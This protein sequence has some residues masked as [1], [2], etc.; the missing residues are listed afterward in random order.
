MAIQKLE[1]NP[2]RAYSMSISAIPARIHKTLV[3]VKDLKLDVQTTAPRQKI[4]LE[5]NCDLH[6]TKRFDVAPHHWRHITLHVFAVHIYLHLTALGV[7]FDFVAGGGFRRAEMNIDSD[8]P[9]SGTHT[10]INDA[11][12]TVTRGQLH[13]ASW[14]SKC[15]HVDA[16]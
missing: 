5:L 15:A 13:A 2:L 4:L 14:A 7:C 8:N 9:L 12:A 1:V 16:S 10:P 11:Q 3:R 6:C